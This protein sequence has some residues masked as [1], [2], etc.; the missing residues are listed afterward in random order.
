[1]AFNGALQRG[2]ALLPSEEF[3]STLLLLHLVKVYTEPEVS[4]NH[5]YG[6]VRVLPHGVPVAQPGAKVSFKTRLHMPQG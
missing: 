6:G 3:L 2:L 5:S 4:P 1:M